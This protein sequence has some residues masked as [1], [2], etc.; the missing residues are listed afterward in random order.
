MIVLPARRRLQDSHLCD[1]HQV[2]TD[3]I[4]LSCMWFASPLE[5]AMVP[6]VDH[7]MQY[8][9]PG[10][11]QKTSSTCTTPLSIQQLFGNLL[12]IAYVLCSQNDPN[13]TCPVL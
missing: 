7:L 2:R 1:Q 11:H 8:V 3:R 9:V 10:S 13:T 5:M 6:H 4:A 12:C